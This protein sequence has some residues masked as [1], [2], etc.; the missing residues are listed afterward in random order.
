MLEVNYKSSVYRELAQFGSVQP[1]TEK[2]SNLKI[3]TGCLISVRSYFCVNLV[4]LYTF[5]TH[6]FH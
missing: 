5:V 4:S 6:L 3:E 2:M 1:N